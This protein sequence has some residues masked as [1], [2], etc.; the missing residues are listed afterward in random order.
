[1]DAETLHRNYDVEH[2]VPLVRGV[3]TASYRWW[4]QVRVPA[5]LLLD[6]GDASGWRA[7]LEPMLQRTPSQVR[8]LSACK[9]AT[10]LTHGVCSWSL[11]TRT[12]LPSAKG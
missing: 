5:N 12:G 11:W 2:Q 6:E 9:L 1:M 7:I 4:R 8:A 3:N 10:A